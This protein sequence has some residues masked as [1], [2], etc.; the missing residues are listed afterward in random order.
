MKNGWVA[1]KKKWMRCG[2]LYF[3]TIDIAKAGPPF[4]FS[5]TWLHRLSSSLCLSP[6]FTFDLIFCLVV[7]IQFKQAKNCHSHLE[8][9]QSFH[10][11]KHALPSLY[12]L[13]GC[14]CRLLT[15]LRIHFTYGDH[16]VSTTTLK[17]NITLAPKLLPL[18][19]KN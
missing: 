7:S 5:E 15:F 4:S 8:F 14:F 1:G 10:K 6:C 11:P 12:G 16:K 17:K 2:V 19:A 18:T 9:N 13:Q 3:T